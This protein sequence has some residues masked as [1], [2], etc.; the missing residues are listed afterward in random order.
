MIRMSRFEVRP[1]LAC[2]AHFS[3]AL[4]DLRWVDRLETKLI[5]GHDKKFKTA[6]RVSS[7]SMSLSLRTRGLCRKIYNC[8]WG[9]RD[10]RSKDFLFQCFLFASCVEHFHPNRQFAPLRISNVTGRHISSGVHEHANVQLFFSALNDSG[11]EL[12]FIREL[13]LQGYLA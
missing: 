4:M 11:Q 2:V 7:H 1:V 5:F 8:H 3:V 9:L 12:A 6:I 10:Y 13:Q